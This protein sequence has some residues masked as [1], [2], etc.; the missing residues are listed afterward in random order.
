MHEGYVILMKNDLINIVF[1]FKLVQYLIKKIK[2]NL[3]IS[4]AYNSIVISIVA[5]LLYGFTN[6]LILTTALAL[7]DCN[8]S[9]LT[10]FENSLLLTKS[11][12]NHTVMM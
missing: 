4:I 2:K 12:F 7:L 5:E 10:L 8:R 6:S 1:D 9:D 3:T 11:M